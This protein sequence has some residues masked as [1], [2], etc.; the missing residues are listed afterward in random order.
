MPS[1][2]AVSRVNLHVYYGIAQCDRRNHLLENVLRS[3]AVQEPSQTSKAG[4]NFAALTLTASW[5]RTVLT[6]MDLGAD[7]HRLP[8]VCAL[9]VDCSPRALAVVTGAD[10]SKGVDSKQFDQALSRG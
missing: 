5:R 4:Q 9:C 3:V 1:A 10:M 2:A 7:A 6:A 8:L